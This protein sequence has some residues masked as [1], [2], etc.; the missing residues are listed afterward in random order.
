M[1]IRPHVLVAAALGTII[2]PSAH[3]Q[4]RRPVVAIFAH[5]DDE[6]VIGPLLSRRPSAC[7]PHRRHN[8]R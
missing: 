2:P 7:A 8:P 5:P 1:R 3:A 4:A 6:R